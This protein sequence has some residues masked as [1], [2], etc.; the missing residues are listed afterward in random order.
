MPCVLAKKNMNTPLNK[1]STTSDIEK[2]FDN[3]VERFSNIDTGQ[4]TT[5]DASLAME[6]IT[7][8]A[9]STT[10]VILKVLDI[11][12]GAG[13]NTI[14]LLRTY[15]TGFDCD[16]I[17]LSMPM[18]ERAKERVSQETQGE[19]N[20]F[21]GD[22]RAVDLTGE[23]YDVIIAAAVLHHLR[24]YQDWKEVF[25]KI[26]RLL[27]PGGS[28]WVTDLVCHENVSIQ[29]L[30]W[31]RYGN[32]LKSKGGD[33]YREKVFDYIDREDSPR[34]VTFQLDLMRDSGFE[35]V[36]VLHKNSCFSAFGGIKGE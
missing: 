1:K 24:E 36:D 34:S 21:H 10:P 33:D 31:N 28:F 9:I 29:K 27:K 12:C 2:R 18:L 14:K 8:A 6:L 5:I 22:F 15:G 23:S 32:Y 3:D 30:M 17:D 20:T 7:E 19:I 35:S 16:L 11:G 25:A 4:V 26:F 13:N